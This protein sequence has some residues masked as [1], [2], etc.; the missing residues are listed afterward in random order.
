MAQY[1]RK[2]SPPVQADQFLPDEDSFPAGV[3][4]DGSRSSTGWVFLAPGG[5]VQVISPGDWVVSRT[6]EDRYAVREDVF[7]ALYETDEGAPP[8]KSKARKAAEVPV[9]APVE[10]PDP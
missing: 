2:P 6:P 5:V 9:P 4:A 8:P 1:R 7:D 10:T 3:V